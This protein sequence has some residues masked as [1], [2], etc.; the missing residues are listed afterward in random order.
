MGRH[1]RAIATGAVI[2]AVVLFIG[3][4]CA[5]VLTDYWWGEQIAPAAAAFLL[6]IHLLRLSLDAL[7]VTTAAAWFIGNLFVVYRAVSVVQIP[8]YM[9]NLEIREALT[10]RLLVTGAVVAGGVLGLV[11]GHGAS[12]WWP[13]VA[14]AWHGAG[15]GMTEPLLNRDLGVYAAQLPLWR[16]LHGYALLLAILGLLLVIVLYL[17]VGSVRWR[18][19]RPAISDHA[20]RHVGLLFVAVALCLVWGYLLEPYELVGGIKRLDDAGTWGARVFGAQLLAGVALG[21]AVASAIWAWRPRHT[22][23]LSLWA[24]LVATSLGVH[25]VAP[26]VS[27]DGNPVVSEATARAL[28]AIAFELRGLN[29]LSVAPLE[30]PGPGRP[31]MALW[32]TRS[33]AL[34]APG[35]D[36]A[37]LVA[38]SPATVSLDGVRR[39]VWLMVREAPSEA[40][41]ISAI[42][43]DRAAANGSAMSYRLGDTVAYPS[44]TTMLELP[45]GALHPLARLYR[46]DSL[47]AGFRV[48]SW[49]RRVM[50]AWGLQVG[51]VLRGLPDN[52]TITWNLAPETRLRRLA[53]FA[54]WDAPV[55]RVVDGELIWVSTGYVRSESFPLVAEEHWRGSDVRV[56]A[57][58]FLGT[59][60]SLTGETHVYHRQPNDPL[61]AAWASL[62][63]GVV[64]PATAIPGSVERVAPYPAELF[65]M[66]ARVLERPAWGLGRQVQARGTPASPADASVTWAGTSEQP[67]MTAAYA[68]PG[69]RLVSAVLEGSR[70]GRDVLRLAY[71]DSVA[72]TALP[73]VL[74]ARWQRFPLYEQIRD[75]VI[76]DG[77]EFATG[78]VRYSLFMGGVL[79]TQAYFGRRGATG[80]PQLTWTAVGYH[81]RLGAGRNADEAWTNMLGESAPAP[82]G[83]GPVSRFE[84]ARRWM[85]RADSALRTG[86]WEDFGTA[87]ES[88]RRVF[89][90]RRDSAR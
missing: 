53:P 67:A 31:L 81:E 87:F 33:V 11:V 27:R 43:G 40:T 17:V 88:L 69:K 38:V 75:S 71:L 66:Q 70:D 82:P 6:Q 74:E 55:P 50:L 80:R 60:H 83:L 51:S 68:Q 89:E 37:E 72:G 36:S 59:V 14:V 5:V 24:I 77:A 2:L 18:G 64:E 21:T 1:G 63:P 78:P 32:D 58:G 56:V 54:E 7:A 84:E 4:W 30:S 62:A 46:V 85:V 42:A 20:R 35:P 19:G 76:A 15:Y 41:L 90:V 44:L 49:F 25:L 57:A 52:S 10:P 8:R 39:P 73:Q 29:T 48:D 86:R 34:L 3:R 61:S 79:A 45:P 26:G 65:R 9:A 13:T 47:R 28:E 16:L 12:T 23:F 22:L